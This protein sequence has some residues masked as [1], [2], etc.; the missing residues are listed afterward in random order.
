M[1]LSDADVQK[2]VKT[3]SENVKIERIL[4]DM[5]KLKIFAL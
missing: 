5:E 1:A 2:Q 3:R 4:G